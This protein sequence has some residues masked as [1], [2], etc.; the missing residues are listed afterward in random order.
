MISAGW[1]Y[2]IWILSLA[3][4]I[5][6]SKNRSAISVAPWQRLQLFSDTV[7][8]LV[9]RVPMSGREGR[10]LPMGPSVTS[11]LG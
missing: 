1:A 6:W 8:F 3:L 9:I 5:S 10:C 7:H 4:S 2:E 11:I